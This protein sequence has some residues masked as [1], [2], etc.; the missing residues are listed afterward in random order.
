[1]LGR[2]PRVGHRRTDMVRFHQAGEKNIIERKG[3]IGEDTG[4]LDWREK[5]KMGKGRARLQPGG[6]AVA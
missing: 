3:S 4:H 5:E 1:M 2:T 6:E